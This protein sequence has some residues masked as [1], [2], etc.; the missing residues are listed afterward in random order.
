MEDEKNIIDFGEIFV[1]MTWDDITLKQFIDIQKFYE[2]HNVKDSSQVLI[3][4]ILHILINKDV[5]FI[6]QLPIEFAESIISKLGFLQEPIKCDEPTNSV[7]IGDEKY[8][9]HTENQLKTG[10]YIAAEMAIKSDKHNFA[11]ILG[12]L[13]RKE[14]EIYDSYFENEVL[15]ERIAMFENVSVVKVLP[16]VNF[17]LSL[18]TAQNLNSQL[19]MAAQEAINLLAKDIE[20]FRKSGHLSKLS[21]KLLTKKLKKLQ[22]SINS[23]SPTISN[24]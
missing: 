6:N 17:F 8:T 20:N 9:V 22:K 11:A 21:T 14:G 5:D 19:Y 23:I 7:V 10:E 2:L 12:I 13:C 15:P 18:W 16:I 24:S 3:K 4:D 1:P